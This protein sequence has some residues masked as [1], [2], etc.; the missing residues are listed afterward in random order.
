MKPSKEDL[1]QRAAQAV[2]A[3]VA[4]VKVYQYCS[5]SLWTLNSSH[6]RVAVESRFAVMWPGKA[7]GRPKEVWQ[8]ERNAWR[9]DQQAKAQRVIDASLIALTEAGFKCKLVEEYGWPKLIITGGP[10]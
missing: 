5:F 6:S 9:T 7:A 3:S 10:R 8:A 1:L 4:D 2:L